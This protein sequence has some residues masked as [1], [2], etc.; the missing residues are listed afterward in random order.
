MIMQERLLQIGAW[1]KIN[2][3]AIYGTHSFRQMSE[4]KIFTRVRATTS[5]PSPKAGLAP[6]WLSV[7]RK[8]APR[9]PSRFSVTPAR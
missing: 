2:G 5:T 4:G 1:L 8:P 6:N 3:E 7:R 9:L